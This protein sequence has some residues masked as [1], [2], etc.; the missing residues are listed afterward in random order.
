MLFSLWLTKYNI[1]HRIIDKHTTTGQTSR[2]IV[3]HA[4]TLEFYRM[5]GIDH[6]VLDISAKVKCLQINSNGQKKGLVP[7]GDAGIGQSFYPFISSVTQDEHEE[8][9]Q[10][11][12]EAAGQRVERGLEMVGVA[13]PEGDKPDEFPKVTIRPVDGSNE[14]EEVVTASYVIGCDGAHSGVR[15][16]TGIEM[17]GGTYERTFFVADV[18]CHGPMQTE[19]N[20][21]MCLSS[22]EFVIILPLPHKENRARIIGIVPQELQHPTTEEITFDDCLPTIKKSAPRL[23]V[24]DLRWFAHYRVHHRCA[25]TFQHGNRVFLCGDA[26]HLHSPVGGQGMNTGLGD[27][28]NLAWKIATAWHA[29]AK[30]DFTEHANNLLST[31]TFERRRFAARLVSSNDRLF[32]FIIQQNPFGWLLRNFLIPYVM[33][34]VA[35][36]LNL[37]YF[38]YGMVSQTAIEYGPSDLS[39]SNAG[40]Q[41][42]GK[43]LP[44]IERAY[45]AAGKD[46]NYVLLNGVGWQAHVFGEIGKGENDVLGNAGVPVHLFPWNLEAQKKGFK[47]NAV[48]VVRPDG[49]IG[50]VLEKRAG[51]QQAL[52]NYIQKWMVDRLE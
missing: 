45:G 22:S 9:L 24:D 47:Q 43:R 37:R 32:Q 7:V 34:F 41:L 23:K 15:H 30:P 20:L 49:Y 8:V 27:A 51:S 12:L 50:L 28:T 42:A 29:T 19:G 46:D 16:A 38:L 35:N 10:R 39:Q 44:W 17:K 25:D 26:A 14:D 31:Y 21:N 4:R 40:K 18:F 1:P 33:P 6:E 11:R 48:Y 36:I 52:K 2:A 5:L 3:V 13:L